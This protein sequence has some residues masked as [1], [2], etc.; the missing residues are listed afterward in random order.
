LGYCRFIIEKKADPTLTNDTGVTSLHFAAATAP[1]EGFEKI[2]ALKIPIDSINKNGKTP[3]HVAA[4][5]GNMDAIK[6]LLMGGASTT[7]LDGW[8]RTP[9]EAG[10]QTAF[11]L[12]S[13]HR[14]GQKY[15]FVDMSDDK[16]NKK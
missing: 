2:L 15:E 3:L 12:I 7:I 13:S 5:K 8:G 4:E 14:P 10:K 1:K 9:Q 6:L 11:N 16:D